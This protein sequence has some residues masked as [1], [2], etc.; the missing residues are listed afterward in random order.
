MREPHYVK[1]PLIYMKKMMSG[2]VLL[3]NFNDIRMYVG[4]NVACW[5]SEQLGEAWT[6]NAGD[7]KLFVNPRS[8]KGQDIAMN[9]DNTFCYTEKKCP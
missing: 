1:P 6:F 7:D 8:V 2:I 3:E 5:A 9:W 4:G